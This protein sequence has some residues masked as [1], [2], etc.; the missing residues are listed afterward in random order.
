MPSIAKL[1]VGPMSPEI[2]EAVFSYSHKKGQPLML[3][4]SKNQID[5]DGGYCGAWTT[6]EYAGYIQQMQNKYPKAK[7]YI[8]RDHCGVG[9]KNDD[10]EDVYKT[11]DADIENSFDLIHVDFCHLKSDYDEILQESKKAIEYILKRKSDM[12]LEIGTDEN[13]G[14]FKEDFKRVEA[15][16]NFFTSF[17]PI[18]FFVTQTGSLVKEV[19]QVGNFNRPYIEKTRKLANKY[20]LSLKEHNCDYLKA[21]DITKRR[22]LIDAVNVAPQYGVIQTKLTLKKAKAYGISVDD[23][24]NDAYESK[25]WKKWLYKNDASN[26]HL[27]AIIAGHYVFAN[28]PYQKLYKKINQQEDFKQAVIDEVSKN[29]SLYLGNL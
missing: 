22:G 28:M 3:I 20:Q 15:Q 27:C 13:T 9:F 16:M 25:K 23:F 21:T 26:K 2:V 5:W 14:E 19:E 1:G 4:A 18:Q 24:L 12:L 6:A 29:F 8:C 11:I 17:A 10:L 7:V